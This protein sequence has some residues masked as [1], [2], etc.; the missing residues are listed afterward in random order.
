MAG[1]GGGEE[2]PAAASASP[3]TE[4]AEGQ[5]RDAAEAGKAPVPEDGRVKEGAAPEKD[6][7]AG[8]GSRESRVAGTCINRTTL[9]K[10]IVVLRL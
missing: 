4:A 10:Y 2:K 3:G 8:A 5:V 1:N 7:A 6:T 9:L